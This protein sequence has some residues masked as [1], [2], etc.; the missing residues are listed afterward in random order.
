MITNFNPFPNLMGNR[1]YL[2][3]LKACDFSGIYEYQSNKDNFPYVDMPIYTSEDQAK[4]YIKKMNEGVHEGKWVIWAITI[5]Q[6]IIGTLS[7]WNLDHKHAS[8]ELAYGL[9]SDYR[10]KGYMKE[11]LALVEN[12]AKKI[13]IKTLMAYTSKKNKESVCFLENNGYRFTEE[14]IEEGMTSNSP[15]VMVVYNKVII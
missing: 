12:Y 1:L 2:R 4:N 7:I 3:Q 15:V 5:D 11:A 13:K 14:V 9:F 8:G 6:K 10:H